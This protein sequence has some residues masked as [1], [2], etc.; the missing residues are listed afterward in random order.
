MAAV[1]AIDCDTWA[2][3]RHLGTGTFLPSI[4]MCTSAAAVVAVRL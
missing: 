1:G 4:T 2:R 3:L